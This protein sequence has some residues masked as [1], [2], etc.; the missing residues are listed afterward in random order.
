MA[1]VAFAAAAF[2][3]L[4]NVGLMVSLWDEPASPWPQIS[5]AAAIVK[6]AGIY[7]SL[8]Y[9]LTGIVAWALSRRRRSRS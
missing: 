6:F 1:W 3:Y 4:E 7:A 5:K 8:A 9:A 2:D